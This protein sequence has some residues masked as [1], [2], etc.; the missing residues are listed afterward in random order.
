MSGT[1]GRSRL[2]IIRDITG[3]LTSTLDVDEV[4]R[5]IV[6]LTAEAMQVKGGAL[7]LLN[8]TTKEFHLSAS[9]GLSQAYLS[10]GAVDADLS[11][12][13]CL[14]GEAVH[15]PDVRND[16]RV[17]YP[18]SAEAEGIRSILSVPM[19]E[20]SRVI[21]VLRLYTAEPREFT[22]EDIEFVHALADL[23]VL[24][25]EHAR[26]FSSLQ[27]AHHSLIEDYHTAFESAVYNPG[28]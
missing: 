4:L 22:G 21:G 18:K 25:L 14:E 15:I 7:R 3:E 1:G 26:L 20:M 24:A 27:E 13:A 8:K 5:L 19:T 23:G 2:G 28:P 11:I 6:R 17:Q 16:P 12:A 9:W 10:K